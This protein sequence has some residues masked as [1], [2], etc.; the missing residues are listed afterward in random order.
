MVLIKSLFYFHSKVTMPVKDQ[1][2]LDKIIT[3]ID[4]NRNLNCL[5]L[6]IN[7][8]TLVGNGGGVGGGGVGDP[9]I[10]YL[11]GEDDFPKMIG[12]AASPGT[13]NLMFCSFF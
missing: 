4:Q 2:D 13:V 5:R 11:P 10:F 12:E 9:N 8:K 7:Q 1:T 3:L 6:T